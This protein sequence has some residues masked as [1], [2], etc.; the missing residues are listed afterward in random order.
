MRRRRRRLGNCASPIGARS[1]SIA[2]S[3]RES[4]SH[5]IVSVTTS[6]LMASGKNERARLRDLMSPRGG[7]HLAPPPPVSSDTLKQ[8]PDLARLDL[9]FR[10][11]VMKYVWTSWGVADSFA[12]AD[13]R[14]LLDASSLSRGE[15]HRENLRF[16]MIIPRR[17][18][19]VLPSPTCFG[20]RKFR[21]KLPGSFSFVRRFYALARDRLASRDE[22]A[23]SHRIVGL[24]MP[25]P[26]L[27]PPLGASRSFNYHPLGS[28]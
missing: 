18:P 17:N 3:C 7:A 6:S 10:S 16:Q 28:C 4:A 24:S 9:A 27:S 23:V 2:R 13:T 22:T 14:Q 1:T 19:P 15:I 5:A 25:A 20:P 12:I 8:A 26:T 11:S 21:A